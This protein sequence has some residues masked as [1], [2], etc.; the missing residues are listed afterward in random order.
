ERLRAAT[1]GRLQALARTLHA[2]SSRPALAGFPGRL[3]M[4][5]RHTAELTHGLAR[6]IAATLTVRERRVRQLQR[7]LVAV[8]V[9][10]RLG[11]IRARLVA[12]QGRLTG[13]VGRRQQRAE[14]RFRSAVD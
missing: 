6:A 8:D 12:A 2:V 9:G 4:R 10:R 3:A 1:D 5:S 14:A 13:G 7:Q 11:T